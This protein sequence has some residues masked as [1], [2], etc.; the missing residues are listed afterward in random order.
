MSQYL[1][2]CYFFSIRCNIFTNLLCMFK[3][4]NYQYKPCVNYSNEIY[5]TKFMRSDSD[6]NL[7]PFYVSIVLK[8]LYFY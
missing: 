5:C 1:S 7:I 6:C 8:A 4:K 2:D 3:S